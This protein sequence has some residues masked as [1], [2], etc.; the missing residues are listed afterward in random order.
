MNFCN[1]YSCRRPYRIVCSWI[2]KNQPNTSLTLRWQPGRGLEYDSC[3]AL[4]LHLVDLKVCWLI[5]MFALVSLLSAVCEQTYGAAGV[6][7]CFVKVSGQR[8][9]RS[10]ACCLIGLLSVVG[11]L[12]HPRFRC[13]VVRYVCSFVVSCS[14]TVIPAFKGSTCRCFCCAGHSGR[15]GPR[16]WTCGDEVLAPWALCFCG[17]CFWGFLSCT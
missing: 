15:P 8:Q 10:F 17:Y 13:P 7:A 3:R 1:Y 16:L 6:V 9:V 5:N 11:T 2:L 14:E 12:I 4:I